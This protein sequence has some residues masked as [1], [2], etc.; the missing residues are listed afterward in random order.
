MKKL[1]ILDGSG[2]LFRAYYAFPALSDVNGFNT[3]VVYGF[4]RMMCK[5]FM[6]KP[7]YLVIA[8]DAP[9][10]NLRHD[11]YPEYKANRVA[12]PEDLKNQIPYTQEIVAQLAIPSCQIPGFEADDIIAT[13]ARKFQTHADVQVTIV[14]SDKDLKQLICDNVICKDPMKNIDI[15]KQDFM[16]EYGFDPVHMLDYLTLIGDSSDNVP[17]ING[18]GPKRAQ[19]LVQQYQTIDNMYANIATMSEDLR[20]KLQEGQSHV[21]LSRKLIELHHITALDTMSLESFKLNIDFNKYNKVLVQDHNFNS[22]AKLID[23][24]KKKRIMPVQEWLF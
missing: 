13:F 1:Y 19:S 17:G 21:A 23:E 22:M 3:N 16:T 4:M 5:L 10:K 20:S 2:F 15:S 6:D 14:S 12:A 9:T 24:L 7:D 18:I 11:M 8:W